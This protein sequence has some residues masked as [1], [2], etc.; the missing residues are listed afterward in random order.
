MLN[1]GLEL[2]L[3]EPETEEKVGEVAVE[4]SKSFNKTIRGFRR[5]RIRFPEASDPGEKLLI[6]AAV[7]LVQFACYLP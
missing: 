6:I 1:A 5:F 7:M 3:L 2:S 4:S